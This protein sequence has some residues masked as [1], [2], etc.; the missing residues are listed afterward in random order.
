MPITPKFIVA[1]VIRAPVVGKVDN[2]IHRTRSSVDNCEQNKPR[3][4]L[5][6]CSDYPVDSVFQKV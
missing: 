4:P 2:V 6:T 3:Y 1:R 5:G